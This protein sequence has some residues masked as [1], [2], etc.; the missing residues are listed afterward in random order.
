MK[1]CNDE[2]K[3]LVV[4]A[5]D[6]WK[7]V[8]LGQTTD[9]G[10]FELHLVRMD[11][12]ESA[13]GS[14]WPANMNRYLARVVEM[15]VASSPSSVFV[16]VKLCKLVFVGFVQMKH[17]EEWINTR[18]ETTGIIEPGN[19]GLPTM[20]GTFLADHAKHMNDLQ[21]QISK[22]QMARIQESLVA[23]AERAANSG[24]FEAMTYDVAM[25]GPDAFGDEPTE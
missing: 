23:D 13:T 4:Q 19:F 16:F 6:R 25:F 10:P 12:M 14:I 1:H 3:A 15:D 22:K 21:A 2:Q 24:S 17:P 7:E 18:V 5:L 9:V 20:F 11:V 8:I